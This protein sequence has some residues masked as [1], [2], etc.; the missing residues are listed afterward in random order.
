MQNGVEKPAEFLQMMWTASLAS[1]ATVF[2][3]GKKKDGGPS[4]RNLMSTITIEELSWGDAGIINFSQS[5]K[6]L[7]FVGISHSRGLPYSSVS[8]WF[9]KS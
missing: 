7:H 5:C 1:G 8:S 4:S 2:G 6:I 3:E 9:Y